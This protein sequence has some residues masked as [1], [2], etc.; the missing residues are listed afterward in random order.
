MKI[1]EINDLSDL[2]NAIDK[3]DHRIEFG[4]KSVQRDYED[5][6]RQV[7]PTNMVS[8]ICDAIGDKAGVFLLNCISRFLDK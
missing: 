8:S 4:K 6:K 3:V 5:L 2:R 1:S 7:V